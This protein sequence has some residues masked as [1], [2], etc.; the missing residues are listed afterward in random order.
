MIRCF[1]TAILITMTLTGSLAGVEWYRS[2]SS[3][4]LGSPISNLGPEPEGWSISI[5]HGDVRET[6]SLYLDGS[7]QFST[8]FYRLEGRLTAREELDARGDILS[9]VEYAY[10]HEGNPRIFYISVESGSQ[11]KT[12][13]ESDTFVN[14]EGRFHR[15]IGGAGD[16]WRI[17]DLNQSGLPENSRVLDS[18]TVVNESSW[19]RAEDGTLREEVHLNGDEEH[20]S[21][22]DSN[23]RLLEETTVRN[24]L[25]VLHRAFLWTGTNL[26]RI[27]E[28]GEGRV[29]VRDIQ[30]SGDRI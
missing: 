11:D 18:G 3:G 26:T 1:L 29:I 6:R 12:Y 7:V 13:V 14:P 19:Y 17:T 24:G 25:I 21:R 10:D 5:D 15:H 16:D 20:R 9:R 8:V 23:G 22:Y 28:R 4:I 27:E 30:W 2:S